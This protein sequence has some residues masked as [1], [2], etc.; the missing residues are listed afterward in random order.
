MYRSQPS[1]LHNDVNSLKTLLERSVL[2]NLLNN[3]LNNLLK[4]LLKDLLVQVTRFWWLRMTEKQKSV[5]WELGAP[6]PGDK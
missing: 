4:N 5:S 6:K 1:I 2:K 3:L